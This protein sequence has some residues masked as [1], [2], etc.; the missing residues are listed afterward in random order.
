VTGGGVEAADGEDDGGLRVFA[1]LEAPPL[2][3]LLPDDTEVVVVAWCPG[4]A[5]AT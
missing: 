4:S 3:A 1:E 5:L 2:F